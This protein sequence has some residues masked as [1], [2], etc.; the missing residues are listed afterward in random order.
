[1]R[2]DKDPAGGMRRIMR[3][4][5]LGAPPACTSNEGSPSISVVDMGQDKV[6]DT[7]KFGQRAR[8]IAVSHDGVGTTPRRALRVRT[9][10]RGGT[11][12]MTA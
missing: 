6:V 12:R 1:M 8:G 2:R 5:A 4:V 11:H 9:G 7:L 3:V 10:Q